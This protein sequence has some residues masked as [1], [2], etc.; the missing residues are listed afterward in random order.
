MSF[1]AGDGPLLLF[2][3]TRVQSAEL[4]ALKTS[5]HFVGFLSLQ[6]LPCSGPDRGFGFAPFYLPPFYLH[7]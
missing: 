4:S 3:G 7:L 6:V 1:A 2:F 5:L